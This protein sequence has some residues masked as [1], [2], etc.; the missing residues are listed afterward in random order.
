MRS[1]DV[2]GLGLLATTR[3]IPLGRTY[4]NVQLDITHAVQL[5]YDGVELRFLARHAARGVL[6]NVR[7]GIR[8]DHDSAATCNGTVYRA[9]LTLAADSPSGLDCT[10]HEC[11]KHHSNCGCGFRAAPGQRG[12]R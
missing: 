7:R 11:S 5:Q 2:D 12:R 4:L 9:L 10:G 6:V 8:Y 3:A 1:P